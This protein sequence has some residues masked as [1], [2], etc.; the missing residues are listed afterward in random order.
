MGA[1]SR[2]AGGKEVLPTLL[3]FSTNSGWNSVPLLPVSLMHSRRLFRVSLAISK[4][5]KMSL[6]QIFPELYY[7]KVSPSIVTSNCI[8]YNNYPS[9]YAKTSTNWQPASHICSDIITS[10]FVLQLVIKQGSQKKDK[11]SA[12]FMDSHS[13]FQLAQNWSIWLDFW[14][15]M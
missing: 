4:L 2:W 5:C 9:K 11:K 8:Y 14:M 7:C 10:K 12:S 6:G 15:H 1:V 13:H 3:D